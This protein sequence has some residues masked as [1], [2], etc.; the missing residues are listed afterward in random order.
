MSN[1]FYDRLNRVF[2]KQDLIGGYT[3]NTILSMSALDSYLSS[4]W[5]KDISKISYEGYLLETKML[6]NLLEEYYNCIISQNNRGNYIELA[7]VLLLRAYIHDIKGFYLLL[8][9]G[10]EMQAINIGRSILGREL[11][12]ALCI[13][14]NEYCKELA[15]NSEGKT[16]DER[17]YKLTRPKAVLKRLKQDNTP[18]FNSFYSSTWEEAYSL[19]S[20]ICHND[21]RELLKYYDESDKYYIGLDNNISKYIQYRCS[22]INQNIIVFSMTL[23]LNFNTKDVKIRDKAE[24]IVS[25]LLRYWEEVIS[26]SYKH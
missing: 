18:V 2:E 14:N 10:L 3:K 25:F 6:I 1:I 17:F 26:D 16:E 9:N 13:T 21:V 20:S 15:I 11:V 19:F 8:D 12:L 24:K 23:L 7:K 22:Y 4:N 5:V